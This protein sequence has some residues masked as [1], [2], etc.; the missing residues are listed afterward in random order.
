M[1][2][3]I[4]PISS[5]IHKHPHTHTH[6]GTA[7]AF[8]PSLP[9]LM[10]MR[11]ALGFVSMSVLMIS[12]VLLVEL[13]SGRWRTIIGILGMLPIAIAYV[14]MAGIAYVSPDWRTTQLIITLPWV[15]MLL[16]WYVHVRGGVRLWGISVG[17]SGLEVSRPVCGDNNWIDNYDNERGVR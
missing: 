7:V 2:D 1:L 15:A 11:A 17:R 5:N 6:V 10:V 9:G 13:V 16:M 3:V 8:A 14:L 4:T 12:F